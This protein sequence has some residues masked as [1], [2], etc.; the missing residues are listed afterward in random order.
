MSRVVKELDLICRASQDLQAPAGATPEEIFITKS[1]TH[2][3]GQRVTRAVDI[4]A[5]GGSRGAAGAAPTAGAR[6]ERVSG[7]PVIGSKSALSRRCQVSDPGSPV[8]VVAP[9]A[10]SRR[11][12]LG[13]SALV[14]LRALDTVCG[15]SRSA[16]PGSSCRQ[17]SGLEAVHTCLALLFTDATVS[18]IDVFS[19]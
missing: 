8:R 2:R 9:P 3:R 4:V 19:P 1:G 10:S 12:R 17:G 6:L 11:G 5:G 15:A 7:A 14:V 13:P 18:L 16:Q